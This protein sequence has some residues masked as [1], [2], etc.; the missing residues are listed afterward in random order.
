MSKSVLRWV[1]RLAFYAVALG[2]FTYAASRSLDFIQM[3]MP[4]DNQLVGYLGLL[5]TSGGALAWLMVFIYHA[6]GTGQKGLALVMVVIDLLGEFA[7][8]AFDSLYRSGEAGLIG[9]LNPEEVRMMIIALSA[10][11]AVNIAATFFFHLIDPETSKRMREESARDVLDDE[12]LKAIEQRAPQ[13]ANQMVPGIIAQWE[14]DFTSRFTD[15]TALGLGSLPTAQTRILDA[16]G[17]D[18]TPQTTQ[19]RGI[20]RWMLNMRRKYAKRPAAV[21]T[22]EQSIPSPI[23]QGP[24]PTA[25]RQQEAGADEPARPFRDGPA[26]P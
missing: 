14:A 23:T 7:L 15:M 12:V 3:T 20:P 4:A 25:T 6:N 9:S 26:A 17:N 10:L 8:F 19:A 18:I 5:A 16:D 24:A 13:L 1:A 21:R 2:L 22:Y 11:I